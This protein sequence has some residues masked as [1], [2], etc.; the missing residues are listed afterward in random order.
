MSPCAKIPTVCQR[1]FPCC[2]L[3]FTLPSCSSFPKGTML[4]KVL[5]PCAPRTITYASKMPW[6]CLHR[7][8]MTAAI[9]DYTLSNRWHFNR[10]LSSI[11]RIFFQFISKSKSAMFVPFLF[12]IQS[13]PKIMPG[14]AS[15]MADNLQ[16]IRPCRRLWQ[17]CTTKTPASSSHLLSNSAARDVFRLTTGSKSPT[18]HF[19][20]RVCSTFSNIHYHKKTFL[21]VVN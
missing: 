18:S 14:M 2:H 19:C 3:H 21:Y 8:A 17:A 12:L 20:V 4:H 10:A 7:K 13:W 16:N 1:D 9:G 5:V 6:C 11:L 15:S